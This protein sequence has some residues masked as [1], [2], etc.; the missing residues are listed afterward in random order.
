VLA[1]IEQ[2]PVGH[3]TPD[4]L[5]QHRCCARGYTTAKEAKVAELVVIGD[6]IDTLFSSR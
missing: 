1:G 6:K 4:A 3:T 2:M 5:A